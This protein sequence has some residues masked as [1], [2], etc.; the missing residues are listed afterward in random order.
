MPEEPV[1]AGHLVYSSNYHYRGPRTYFSGGAGLTSTVGDYARFLQMILNGGKLD[2][3]RILSRKTVELMSANSM[4]DLS[5]TSWRN[6]VGDKGGL[7]FGIRTERGRHDG[8][9]SI[10]TLFWGGF[11][12]THMWV[13]P[14][15][16]MLGVFMCQL[17]PSGDLTLDRIFKNLAFQAVDD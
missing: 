13:D 5:I 16:D 3:V 11:F 10:G 4:G 14:V 2:S 17:C 12:Y 9:E 6:S 7:G 1:S 15:E 8:I